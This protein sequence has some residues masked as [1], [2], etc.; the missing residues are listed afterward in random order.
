M[1]SFG[2]QPLIALQI[3]NFQQSISVY[4]KII[5]NV[6]IRNYS[7][8]NVNKIQIRQITGTNFDLTTNFL[9]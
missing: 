3:Q 9:I 1:L 8:S 5:G 6:L 2:Q 7:W 4:L